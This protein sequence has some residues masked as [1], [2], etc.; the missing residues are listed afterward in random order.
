MRLNRVART[1]T[2]R[3]NVE[4]VQGNEVKKL[5]PDLLMWKADYRTSERRRQ[6]FSIRKRLALRMAFG[7]KVIPLDKI[8]K[9]DQHRIVNAL[10]L[11]YSFSTNHQRFL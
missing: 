11:P 2:K 9:V 3:Q 1:K 8:T 7:Q 4:M 5:E 10:F 6:L